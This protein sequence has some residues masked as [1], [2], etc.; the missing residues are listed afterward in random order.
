MSRDVQRHV[1]AKMPTGPGCRPVEA[2]PANIPRAHDDKAILRYTACCGLGCQMRC[3]ARSWHQ[4]SHLWLTEFGR[5]QS[6]NP[7][8]FCK[9]EKQCPVMT[10][11]ILQVLCVSVSGVK[12]L[13]TCVSSRVT[14]VCVT[15]PGL[16]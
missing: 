15:R 12:F 3:Q 14:P 4:R 13:R 6:A 1:A 11:V 5:P 16:K 2:M 10:E 8:I 9:K 7:V